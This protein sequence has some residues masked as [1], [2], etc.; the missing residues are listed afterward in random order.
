M[1]MQT[2]RNEMKLWFQKL[3]LPRLLLVSL[4]NLQVSSF[5]SAMRHHMKVFGKIMWGFT[6]QAFP[7]S[8][9]L[10]N[11]ESRRGQ[12]FT[13]DCATALYWWKVLNSQGSQTPTTTEILPFIFS[14]PPPCVLVH[15]IPA[16]CKSFS[17]N[18]QIQRGM[19]E[20]LCHGAW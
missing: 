11:E 8:R 14:F 5:Q 4:D 15:G 2:L 6:T 3:C 13:A 16:P 1:W 19:A 12:S 18:S 20:T 7:V 17:G 9:K 10:D